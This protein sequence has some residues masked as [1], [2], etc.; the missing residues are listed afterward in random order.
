MSQ[1]ENSN[2]AGEDEQLEPPAKPPGPP[3]PPVPD[4]DQHDD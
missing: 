4:P 2:T 1:I 3:G